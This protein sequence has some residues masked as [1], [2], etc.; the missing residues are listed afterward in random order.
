MRSL[1]VLAVAVLFFTSA[2]DQ[3]PFHLRERPVLHGYHLE[4][5]EDSTTFYLVKTGQTDDDGGGA[6]NGTVVRIGW[7]ARYIA[8]ERKANFAGDRD[9]WMI[10]D[11]ATQRIIGPLSDSQFRGRN[12]VREI[13]VMPAADAWKR[14]R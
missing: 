14:L 2:C 13:A 9:G 4:Q 11:T 12:E 5:W 10:I 6:L 7:N 1:Q 8:A 3:D